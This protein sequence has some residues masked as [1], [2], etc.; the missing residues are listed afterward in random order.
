MKASPSILTAMMKD[1]YARP[2]MTLTELAAKYDISTAYAHELVRRDFRFFGWGAGR[3]L[4]PSLKAEVRREH[5]WHPELSVAQLAEKFGVSRSTVV[6]ALRID[7]NTVAY[8]RRDHEQGHPLEQIA[9]D[10]SL[11]LTD[12]V[13][14][15][16]KK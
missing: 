3:R 10:N 6:N 8:V 15:L 1:W 14:I 7:P 4:S 13:K 11:P 2:D 16:R 9:K 5:L 12:V